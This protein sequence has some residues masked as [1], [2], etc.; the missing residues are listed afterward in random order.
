MRKS[1]IRVLFYVMTLVSVLMLL[2]T[3]RYMQNVKVAPLVTIEGLKGSYMV[4]G[5]IYDK[6]L[7]LD[8]GKYIVS[9]ES[10]L[11]LFGNRVKV[12]KIPRFEVEVLW[13]K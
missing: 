10:V 7:S 11:K 8:Q 3:Y 9:G 5:K 1:L 4:N 12:V 2:F 13:E 6:A